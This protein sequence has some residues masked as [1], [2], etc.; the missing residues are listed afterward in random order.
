[1]AL[2]TIAYSCYGYSTW[3]YTIL[4]KSLLCISSLQ[5]LAGF[6]CNHFKLHIKSWWLLLVDP[7]DWLVHPCHTRLGKGQQWCAIFG[8]HHPKN[9]TRSQT[10]RRF[11]Q[12]GHIEG[13][14][15]GCCHPAVHFFGHNVK[16]SPGKGGATGHKDHQEED[17]CRTHGPAKSKRHWIQIGFY[18]G[19]STGW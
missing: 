6:E 14:C 18:T 7:T 19:L 10:L 5:I 15:E 4:K 13:Q 1:M 3:T 16:P 12:A 8:L 9:P 17:W 11:H 2:T